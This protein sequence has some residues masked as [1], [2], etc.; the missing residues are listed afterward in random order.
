MIFKGTLDLWL[1]L[2][3][4]NDVIFVALALKPL[5]VRSQVDMSQYK[6]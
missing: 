1:E 4:I 5:S 3:D 6:S 2:H